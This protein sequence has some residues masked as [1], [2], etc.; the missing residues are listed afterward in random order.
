MNTSTVPCFKRLLWCFGTFTSAAAILAAPPK[1]VKALPDN[2][3]TGVD[4]DL[5][6]M[7][8][9]FDQPMS[10]GGWSVVGGGPNFPKLVGK[11]RWV[12]E[13]TFTWS[14]RLEPEHEYW[15]G[16][17][18]PSF[19]NFRSESGE[20]AE[21]YPVG[22]TT[23]KRTGEAAANPAARQ[24]AL[25]REAVVHLKRSLDEDYSYRDLRQTNWDERFAQFRPKLETNCAPRQF[26]EA[27]AELLSPAQD[28]H[29]WLKVNGETIPTWKRR[30]VWNVA[31]NKLPRFVPRWQKRSGIVCTGEFGDG[32]RYLFI[33]SWPG[34][35]REE[36]EP[37]YEAL[38]DAAEAGKPLIIDVRANGGGSE[39]LAAEF[40]GCF[41][42]KPAVY[43]KDVIRRD[44][45]FSRPLDRTVKP[46][47]ARPK[48]R[49]KVVVLAGAGTVS[50]SESFVMMMK[51]VPGCTIVGEPTAGCSGNPRPVDLGNEVTVFFPSWKDLD[52]DGN[53]LE[54]KGFA[55]MVEV[56]TSPEAF[57]KADPVLEAALKLLRQ[58]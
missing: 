28:I 38:T 58:K 22:F 51:Q 20:P 36:L 40:A 7:R 8:I 55:P 19:K 42:D 2:N 27:A 24:L 14:L 39:D 6:E 9:E 12:D 46:N 47:R 25:N 26:A 18:S 37:A 4:P 54:G 5:R 3:A 29:L 30:A 21:P 41:L 44:G 17:N 32:L 35:E 31:S 43:A 15:F 50:S 34:D 49:G 56:K 23:G 13:R 45:Q 48:Y 1:V 57:D 33:R 52:L 11:A 16:I 53:C 10:H